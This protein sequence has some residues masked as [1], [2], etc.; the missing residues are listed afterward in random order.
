MSCA[1]GGTSA[2]VDQGRNVTHVV[3]IFKISQV[4]VLV[5]AESL[6]DVWVLNHVQYSLCFLLQMLIDRYR[7][8]SFRSKF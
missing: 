1:E 5:L 4:L 8:F 6:R 3:V 2:T 7:L